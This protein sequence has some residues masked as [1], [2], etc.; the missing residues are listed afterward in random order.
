MTQHR[1]PSCGHHLGKLDDV[2]IHPVLVVARTD[3]D[4][5]DVEGDG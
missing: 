3:G 1:V 5:K 4:V 2:T